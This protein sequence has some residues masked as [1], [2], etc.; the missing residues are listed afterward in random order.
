MPKAT[1]VRGLTELELFVIISLAYEPKHLYAVM[2]EIEKRL[3]YKFAYPSIFERARALVDRGD[4]EQIG[5]TVVNG[6]NRRI[7]AVTELGMNAL[8][9]AEYRL[10]QLTNWLGDARSRLAERSQKNV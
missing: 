6:R 3:G 10:L 7:F 8:Y 5:T 1:S 4:L 2:N 9:Q